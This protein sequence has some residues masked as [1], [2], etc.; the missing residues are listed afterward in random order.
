MQELAKEISTYVKYLK[1]KCNL[2]V[3]LHFKQSVKNILLQKPYLEIVEFNYHNNPYCLNIKTKDELYKKCLACQ[4]AVM[5]KCRNE[6]FFQGACFADV[7]EYVF[8]IKKDD[9]VMGFISVS[10][11]KADT[12]RMEK[13]EEQKS[14]YDNYL[15][16]GMVDA[17]YCKTLIAPLC[18]M[19]ELLFTS[20]VSV[21]E[22]ENSGYVS[23]LN[24][25]SENHSDVSLKRM[26]SFLNYSPSYISHTFKKN[27]GNTIKNYCN[28]LK[29]A[30]AKVFLRTTDKS[31]SEVAYMSGFNDL[32]Y[33]INTFKKITGTTPLNWRKKHK[34][35]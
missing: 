15:K 8:A 28:I 27:N 9:E 23:I 30:D 5:I 20:Y 4:R 1:T 12:E 33:F 17:K 29:I 34:V 32:S 21:I 35:K 2:Q 14:F 3:S 6:S 24:Y 13:T 18:R 31:V 25:L 19:L 10:G 16:R 22:D 11:F 26:A 7:K